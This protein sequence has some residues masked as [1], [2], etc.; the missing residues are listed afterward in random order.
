MKIKNTSTFYTFQGVAMERRSQAVKKRVGKMLVDLF[1]NH[2]INTPLLPQIEIDTGIVEQTK[3]YGISTYSLHKY[4][5]SRIF[6]VP[7]A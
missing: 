4:L 3:K 2:K 7:S 6:Q 5:G 1:E